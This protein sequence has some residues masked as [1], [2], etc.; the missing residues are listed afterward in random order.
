MN[1][2]EWSNWPHSGKF[3]IAIEAEGLP[4]PVAQWW[5]GKHYRAYLYRLHR[6]YLRRSLSYF[7][8]FRLFSF[9]LPLIAGNEDISPDVPRTASYMLLWSSSIISPPSWMQWKVSIYGYEDRISLILAESIYRDLPLHSSGRRVQQY[10]TPNRSWK[11]FAFTRP[12]ANCLTAFQRFSSSVCRK[13]RFT[14]PGYLR[15]SPNFQT[16]LAGIHKAFSTS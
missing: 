15:R 11:I 7:R 5:S 3:F 9:A 12:L 14:A 4:I 1:R 16:A 13:P 6:L 8:I 10:I 2:H